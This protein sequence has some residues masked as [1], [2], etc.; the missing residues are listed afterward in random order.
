MTHCGMFLAESASF[1]RALDRYVGTLAGPSNGIWIM[2]EHYSEQ[3][4]ATLSLHLGVPSHEIELSH[5]LYRDWGLTPLMLVIV[6]LDL[7]R[8][9]AVELPPHELS[10]LMTVGDLV[11]R[12]RSWMH[13]A[14]EATSG[15]LAAPVPDAFERLRRRVNRAH[16]VQRARRIR[17]ELHR[18]RWLES[19]YVSQQEQARCR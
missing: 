16:S 8:L 5:Q 9:V 3:V 7:E 6:L 18:L 11:A 4:L 19:S 13:R 12:F 15:A 17:R 1:S 10:D 2:Q 14:P